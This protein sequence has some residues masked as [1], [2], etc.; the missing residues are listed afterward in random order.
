[1]IIAKGMLKGRGGHEVSGAFE[2]LRVD[3][4]LLFRTDEEF[5]FDGSP[6]PAFALTSNGVFNEQQALAT[7]FLNLP[8]SGSLRGLKSRCAVFKKE[9]FPLN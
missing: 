4:R 2:I 6:E 5:Y 8:A 1:M 7:R 3:G 9:R